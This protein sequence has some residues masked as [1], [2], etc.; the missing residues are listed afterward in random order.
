MRRIRRLA[1]VL[2]A[3]GLVTSAIYATGAFSSLNTSRDA[4]VNVAGDKAGYLGLAPGENGEYTTYQNGKLQLQLNGALGGEDAPRGG[5][6][7]HGAETTITSV[8]TITNQGAQ[9]VGVW[10][11]DTGDH[12]EFERASGGSL[13]QKGNAVELTPGDTVHVGLTID[14]TETDADQ[15]DTQLI[16]NADSDVEGVSSQKGSS[17]GND[18]GR[19]GDGSASD[20]QT[21]SKQ[22]HQSNEKTEKDQKDTNNDGGG[23]LL[24]GLSH[25]ANNPGETLNDAEEAVN[26]FVHGVSKSVWKTLSPLVKKAVKG[27]R[28]LSDTALKMGNKLLNSPVDV[29]REAAAGLLFGGLGMPGGEFTAKESS[30]PY[31]F[32]SW[33][34]STIVPIVD[35]FTG[36]RDLADSAAQGKLISAGVEVVGLIPA[37]GKGAD[38]AKSI[39]IAETWLGPF[40]SKADEAMKMLNKGYLSKLMG[41]NKK[42][43]LDKFP[44]GSSASKTEEISMSEMDTYIKSGYDP[45][46]IDDMVTNGKFTKSDINTLTGKNANLKRAQALQNKGVPVED[47][48]YYVKNDIDLQKVDELKNKQF[49]QKFSPKQTRTILKNDYSPK[50]ISQ[51]KGHRF[52]NDQITT[53]AKKGVDPDRLKSMKAD[54]WKNDQIT[55]LVKND[56]SQK[57]IKSMKAD[58]WENDQI[59]TLTRRGSDFKEAK[60]LKQDGLTTDDI[61]EISKNLNRKIPGTNKHLP[62]TGNL[63]KVRQ[64]KGKG[65]STDQLKYLTKNKISLSGVKYLDKYASR[66]RIMDY[67]KFRKGVGLYSK[68]RVVAGWRNGH[69]NKNNDVPR[70][71]GCSAEVDINRTISK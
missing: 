15:L 32:L 53:F 6:V 35:I 4:N 57:R 33:M 11:E 71:P 25:A 54:G 21:E 24:S 10:L 7:N 34:G 8:F 31:Y 48:R 49:P 68:C 38:V 28:D 58:G 37:V 1:I 40:A 18:A 20:S 45:A 5:G 30:S 13:E 19:N 67:L 29:L 65:Y 36:L 9:S 66:N 69:K 22:S 26:D 56:V 61:T 52:T 43:L 23:G 41:E 3:V 47:I 12:I 50:Q 16:I 63:K 27:G 59:T 44:G 39:G 42:K 70:I 2:V 60:K 51:L 62:S 14:T 64:L 46:R 17:P 55:T